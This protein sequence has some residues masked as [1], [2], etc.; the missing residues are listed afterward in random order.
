MASARTKDPDLAA[1]LILYLASDEG[2]TF[3]AQ[4]GNVAPAN[5]SPDLQKL[6][7]D[8]FN[9]SKNIQAFV[10]ATKDSQGVTVYAEIWDKIDT[11]IVVNIFDLDMSVDDAVKDA[12]DF[13]NANL[14]QPAM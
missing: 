1:N 3:F 7:I 10:D 9:S 13:I 8:S 2:Q 6:W 12:C 11:E 5:P 14:P 4:S